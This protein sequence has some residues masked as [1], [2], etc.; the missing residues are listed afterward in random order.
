ML[1]LDTS[2]LSRLMRAE[3]VAL[4][5]AGQ[6]SPGDLFMAPPVAAEIQFGIARKNQGEG[7]HSTSA[8]LAANPV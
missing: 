4:G 5:H 1:V 8:S 3:P 2:A 6:H 7:D